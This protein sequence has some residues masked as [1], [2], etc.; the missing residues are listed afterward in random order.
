MPYPLL[1]KT[2]IVNSN[3]IQAADV[4]QSIDAFTG[5]SEYRIIVSGSLAVYGGVVC[6]G[7]NSNSQ[8]GFTGSLTGTALYADT[9][10]YGYRS[11][12]SNVTSASFSY[13]S[14]YTSGS[15]QGFLVRSGSDAPSTAVL[16][17]IGMLSGTSYLRTGDTLRAVDF[18][19]TPLPEGA[20]LGL[21][22]WVTI[23]QFD[24][25]ERSDSADSYVTVRSITTSSI[26]FQT[27]SNNPTPGDLPFTF[28]CVYQ[29]S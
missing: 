25:R 21:N 24:N 26:T 27:R 16:Y 2:N 5:V 7:P 12:G 3:T 18:T 6:T 29:N 28:I 8:G 17:P 10:G 15:L 19:A 13:N 1:S 14:S 20:T 9:A 11:T 22:V 23:S 4:S